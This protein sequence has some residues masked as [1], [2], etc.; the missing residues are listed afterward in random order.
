MKNKIK[1][2]I[3]EGVLVVMQT[4]SSLL[5]TYRSEL[6]DTIKVGVIDL[7]EKLEDNVNY[8][9]IDKSKDTLFYKTFR[10]YELEENNK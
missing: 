8:E 3:N 9:K 4:L 7:L 10:E 5:D 1:R 6:P 2:Q